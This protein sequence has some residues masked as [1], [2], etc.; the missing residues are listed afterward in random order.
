MRIRR[1]LRDQTAEPECDLLAAVLQDT[2]L[3]ARLARA[4]GGWRTLSDRELDA[5]TGDSDRS[6]AVRA[7]QHLV[8]RGYPEL[9]RQAMLSSDTVGRVYAVR[10]QAIVH[11]V[12]LAVALDGRNNLLGEIELA[13]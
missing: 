2:E 3:A 6:N 12:L 7:L 4:P 1:A 9:P 10:L 5:L 11:E 13:S 8:S